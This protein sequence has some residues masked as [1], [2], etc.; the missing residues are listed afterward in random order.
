MSEEEAVQK[1][2]KCRQYTLGALYGRDECY[3][4]YQIDYDIENDL[5]ED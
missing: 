4:C 3:D 1:C 5:M 2:A